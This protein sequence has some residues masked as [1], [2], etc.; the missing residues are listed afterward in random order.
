MQR[1]GR[2]LVCPSALGEFLRRSPALPTSAGALLEGN[3]AYAEFRRIVREIVPDAEQEILIARGARGADRET[4]RVWAFL[5]RV[6]ERFFPCYDLDEYEQVTCGIPFVRNAWS[7]DRLHEVELPEGDLLLFA[8]SKQPYG[9][10]FDTRVPLLDTVAAHLPPAIMAEIPR[11]GI[12]PDDL[13]AR[14]DGTRFA[15]AADFADWLWGQTGSAFLDLDD[16]V[17]ISDADWTQDVVQQLAEQW[18]LGQALLERVGALARWLE[19][20]PV[21]HF[22]QLLDAAL[23]RDTHIAYERQRRLYACEIT[24]GGLVPVSHDESDP[25]PCRAADEAATKSG[26]RREVGI[27]VP[28]GLAA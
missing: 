13:H 21:R 27:S 4:E 24:D 20:D 18:R 14:L 10:G 19:T 9:T 15:A 7:F 2:R 16:E 22:A 23:G 25:E 28:N 3:G 6:E 1:R 12:S 17:C 5:R 26:N 8:L 11:P